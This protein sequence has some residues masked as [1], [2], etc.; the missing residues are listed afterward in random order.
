M[1]AVQG[2][3]ALFFKDG[4]LQARRGNNNSSSS[5]EEEDEGRLSLT[6]MAEQMSR[7]FPIRAQKARV[8]E[9]VRQVGEYPNPF[10]TTLQCVP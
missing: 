9:K 6:Q 10:V 1:R 4:A 2:G 3:I 5:L 7:D 8:E